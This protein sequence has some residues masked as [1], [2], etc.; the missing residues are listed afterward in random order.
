MNV[1]ASETESFCL[2]K[3]ESS[4]NEAGDSPPNISKMIDSKD[5]IFLRQDKEDSVMDN[6]GSSQ[7][8]MALT[9]NLEKVNEVWQ[10]MPEDIK[11]SPKNETRNT[12]KRKSLDTS[13]TVK[14]P[15]NLE[16]GDGVSDNIGRVDKRV[17]FSIRLG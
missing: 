13:E 15:R 14:K 2:S 16:I 6:L 4:D 12:K 1:G 8:L 9:G 3:S 11:L 7:K 17:N 5:N 10:E